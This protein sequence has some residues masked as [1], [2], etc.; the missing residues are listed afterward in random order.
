MIISGNFRPKAFVMNPKKTLPIKPPTHR[1]DA[2]HEASSIVILP[3]GNGVL[4]EVSKII[5]GDDHPAVT[6]CPIKSKFTI[7]SYRFFQK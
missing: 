2:A 5:F 1:I 3:D 7:R 4:S 6:P